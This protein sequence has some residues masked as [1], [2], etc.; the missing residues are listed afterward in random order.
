MEIA[1]DGMK[2][3]FKKIIKLLAKNKSLEEIFIKLKD[4]IVG[5]INKNILEQN[6]GIQKLELIV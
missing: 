5:N 4:D 1:S 6:V 3:Y 2:C